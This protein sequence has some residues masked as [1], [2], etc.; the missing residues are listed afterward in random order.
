[1]K[2]IILCYAIA[3][4]AL[5]AMNRVHAGEPSRAAELTKIVIFEGRSYSL[6]TIKLLSLICLSIYKNV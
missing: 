4:L 1:M 2:K 6:L 3:L 5:V